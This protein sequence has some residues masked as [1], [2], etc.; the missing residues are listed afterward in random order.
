MSTVIAFLADLDAALV[1][2]PPDGCA[3]TA[4]RVTD[5]FIAR[6]TDFSTEQIQLFDNVIGK[7]ALRMPA[8]ARADLS[9]RIADLDTAP[10][11]VIRQFA[12]D[13]LPVARPVLTR[14]SVLDDNDLISV[15]TLRGRDHMLAITER[16]MLGMVVTD[17]LMVKGDRVITHALAAHASARFSGRGMGLLV[18]RAFADPA[19]Q[20]VLAQRGD[21]PSDLRMSLA[22][23]ATDG[24][25]R[26]AGPAPTLVGMASLGALTPGLSRDEAEGKVR[27]LAADGQLTETMLARFAGD[28][29]VNEAAFALASLARLP[30]AV[31]DLA[32]L[33]PDR[34]ACLVIGKAMGWRWPT[35]RALIGLRPATEQLPHMIDRAH[36]NFDSLSP[37]T[38]QRV[39]QF[40][41]M[42]D[43]RG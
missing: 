6:A 31:A 21:V 39:L 37:T 8:P 32:L 27:A 35:I 7:L 12:H 9:E 18:T 25:K 15:A 30:T 4:G 42:R 10:R 24:I 11:G 14:S 43:A 29:T 3:T 36:A 1:R 5:L 28:G 17:Y 26:R 41:R 16:P 34:D 22:K 40:M 19:L 33:G 20:A 13:E 38:A 23:A 2:R